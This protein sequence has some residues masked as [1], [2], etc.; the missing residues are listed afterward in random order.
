MQG[1]ALGG[2]VVLDALALV[3]DYQVGVVLHQG[4]KDSV[5]VGAFVVDDR[6]LERGE[7][8]DLQ[9]VQTFQAL[10]L[11]SQ[12]GFAVV[13]ES[14]ELLQVVRPDAAHTGRGYYQHPL[15]AVL[16][17]QGAHRGNGRQGFAAAHFK[18]KT[19][20]F[21]LFLASRGELQQRHIGAP[22]LVLEHLRPDRVCCKRFRLF[23]LPLLFYLAG[24]LCQT[25]PLGLHEV[26][27]SEAVM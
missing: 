21:M 6:D 22:D 24:D 10:F 16:L 17:V 3:A 9:G 25:F 4:V 2:A 5:P 12:Q 23:V 20:A 26:R 18:E 19:E 14:G 27:E 1:F 7:R 13:G 8:P 15:D 11:F